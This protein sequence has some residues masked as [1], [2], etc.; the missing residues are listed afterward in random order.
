MGE[1]EYASQRHICRSFLS[2]YQICPRSSPAVGVAL[3][4]REEL[5]GE[6][7]DQ[8]VETPVADDESALTVG[9][10]CGRESLYLVQRAGAPERE[11][12]RAA[13]AHQRVV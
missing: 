10:V 13:L 12:V 4:R 9:A 6:A 7:R 1:P 5:V 11:R 3:R 2:G 8:L